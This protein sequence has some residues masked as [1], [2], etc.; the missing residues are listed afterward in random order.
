MGCR[1]LVNRPVRQTLR[2]L[3]F[4]VSEV[5]ISLVRH[6]PSRCS[7]GDGK[8]AHE[9]HLSALTGASQ[10]GPKFFLRVVLFDEVEF[11]GRCLLGKVTLGDKQ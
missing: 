4:P 7:D 3:T 5:P 10:V 11:R 6:H 2:L 1:E 9:E 8:P